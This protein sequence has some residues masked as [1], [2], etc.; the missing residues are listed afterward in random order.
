MIR[1]NQSSRRYE[2]PL[3]GL[4]TRWLQTN[5]NKKSQIESTEEPESIN[6]S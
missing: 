4:N 5:Y 6:R 3:G 2:L 1:Q